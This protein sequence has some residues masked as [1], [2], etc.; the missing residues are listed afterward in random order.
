MSCIRRSTSSDDSS[1][2]ALHV[3]SSSSNRKSSRFAFCI[4]PM[5]ASYA[6][7]RFSSFLRAD[8]TRSPRLAG[9]RPLP[10]HGRVFFFL[11]ERERRSYLILFHHCHGS[12]Q[13]LE[14]D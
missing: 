6:S 2:L 12:I 13:A 3:R 1:Y 8:C 4:L 10:T 14:P 9:V 11:E 5:L 7:R